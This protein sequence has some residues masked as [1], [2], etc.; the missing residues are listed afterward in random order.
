MENPTAE[1]EEFEKSLDDIIRATE[2][3]RRALVNLALKGKSDKPEY[4]HAIMIFAR[5]A[6][7]SEKE[8]KGL[9]AKI[10]GEDV[11]DDVWKLP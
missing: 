11:E 1:R 4:I 9:R 7:S 5:G 8:L 10:M 6:H 3:F 2:R